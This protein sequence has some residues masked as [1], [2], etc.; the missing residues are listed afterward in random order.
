MPESSTTKAASTSSLVTGPFLI[1]LSPPRSFSSVVSTMIGQH[2]ELYGFPELHLF[3]GDTVQEMLDREYR[4]GNHFGPS[5]LLRTIAQL[6]FGHQT[7][8][9]IAHAIAWLNERKLWST[10]DLMEHLRMRVAPRIGI[11]KSPIT[12]LR[13]LDLERTWVFY[14]KAYFLHLTRHPVSTSRS[15]DLFLQQRSRSS[16][17][18]PFNNLLSWYRFHHNILSFTRSLPPGQSMM[19]KGEDILSDPD[20]YLA[21]IAEWLGV[22]TDD[23]AIAAMKH[24]EYSPYAYYGPTPANG[25]NDSNF[26]R[27]P[28]FRPGRVKEPSLKDFLAR[29]AIEWI[30]LRERESLAA[31][32]YALAESSALTQDVTALAHRLGYH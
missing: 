25:G 2:P 7:R 17:Q 1:L 8:A 16:K 11:E 12:A 9:T 23:A 22:R 13:P 31:A 14:P 3:I 4:A 15:M 26:M 28:V 6:E 32:G 20:R 19:V 30:S 29:E 10:R 18:R 21:Q 5:G 24:P 27:N